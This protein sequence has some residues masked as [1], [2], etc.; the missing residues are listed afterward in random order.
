[1][2]EFLEVKWGSYWLSLGVRLTEKLYSA[3]SIP[4]LPG[5]ISGFHIAPEHIQHSFIQQTHPTRA[6]CPALRRAWG[7]QALDTAPA[8]KALE[9]GGA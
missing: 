6:L 7:T 1:M 2:L 9:W 3:A 5:P 4:P 8:S